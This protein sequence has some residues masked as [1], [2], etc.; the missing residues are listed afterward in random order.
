MDVLLKGGLLTGN[1]FEICGSSGDGKTQLCFTITANITNHLKQ[2]VHY[3]DTKGDF[4]ANR[5]SEI[6]LSQGLLSE[7]CY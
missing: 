7:V 5:L 3:I 6:L 1:V 2:I 4:S